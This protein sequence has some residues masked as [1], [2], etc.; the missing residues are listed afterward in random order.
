MTREAFCPGHVTA[1]FF[2]PEPGPSPEATGS[3]GAGFCVSKG[4]TA[5]V[6][7]VSGGRGGV[8]PVGDTRIAP[9]VAEAL[10]GYLELS[11]G[12]VELQLELDLG[13]PVG[14]GFGMSGAMTLA[15][16]MA[17]EGE[18][19]L[20][21]GDRSRLLAL[22]HSAEV[23]GR[24]GLGDVV[25]QWG[26]GIDLRVRPGLPPSGLVIRREVTARILLGWSGV[27]LHTR[28]VLS[29]RRA[30]ERLETA[31]LPLLDAMGS[32]PDMDE[33]L[34]AGWTFARGAG[35]VG[36]AVERMVEICTRHGHASQVMLGNSVF[37]TGDLD[38]MGEALA[39]EGFSWTVVDVDNRGVRL[40][41]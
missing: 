4:A 40:L 26:G 15:A 34:E 14:H 3:R 2:A 27:P 32:A 41:D 37:A 39:A 10:G 31:A 30:R 6:T 7:A 24:T 36:G 21:G 35:L 18:L 28:S 9:V 11:D 13:L 16:L 29:D 20:A 23:E 33:L 1:L 5:R 25:A 17:A 38:A 12:T 8:S 19:G 22:A